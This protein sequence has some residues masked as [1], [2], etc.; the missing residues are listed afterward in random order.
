[1]WVLV[2]VIMGSALSLVSA[3]EPPPLTPRSYLPLVMRLYYSGPTPLVISALYYDTYRA[4]E[5]DEAFQLYNPLPWPVNLAEWRVSDRLRTVSF[6]TEF[7]L[8]AH[9]KLWC[10]RKAVSFTLSF[11]F[12]PACEYSGDTDP[13]VPDLTGAALQFGNTGGRATL[14]HP[15]GLYSDTLVYEAGDTNVPGWQGLAVYPY[16]PSTN[17]GEEGQILYRKLDQATGLPVPDTDTRADWAQDP[18]D[19]VD[20]RRTQ[21]PGWSL[22]RFFQPQIVT[23][24]ASLQVIVAPDHSYD[25]LRELLEAAQQ[26]IRFEGYTFD[27]ARLGEVIAARARAGV[28]VTLTLEGGPPGGVS[29]QQLWIVQQIAQAGGQVYY[30]RANSATGARKRYA[31]QHGKFWLLDDRLALVG[32]ENPNPE[33]F[34]DDDKTDG[35]YGRRGVYLATDAASVVAGVR[36]Y[37]SADITPDQHGDA[38]AWNPADPTLGAP[39]AGFAPSYASGGTF[40]PVQKPQPLQLQGAFT[41]Q[42]ISSPEQSLRTRDSLLGLV[43]QAG[44]GDTVLVEQLY[45]QLFWGAEDS[46][47]VDDPNPRL[48]AYLA[49][50]R[51][52]A[53]VR[54]LLDAYFDNQDLNSPRSNLRTVEYLNAL[55]ATEGLDLEARRRNPTGLGIHNKMALAQVGGQGWVI[56]GSLNGG[57]VSAKLNRELALKVASDA[58]YDYLADLFWYDWGVTP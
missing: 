42:L 6:P 48:E 34:P 56:I 10:A 53:T 20:G 44:R 51:R 37:M 14:I 41:F 45:E 35:T 16:R 23:E 17:F 18:A 8:D 1:M 27:N 32:S 25:A 29:D 46:N 26:S 2:V 36:A 49:A 12:K 3:Q 22:E 24:P 55:A 28:Q 52:G 4:N 40:Y 58:A 9:A 54:V 13:A 47:V 39:P 19:L 5:P 33:A 30:F 21:Y 11:G 38:W 31:Y 43:A 7:S 57:E 15:Q 50:A